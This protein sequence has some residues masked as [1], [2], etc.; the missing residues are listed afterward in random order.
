METLQDKRRKTEG[1][2]TCIPL[3]TISESNMSMDNEKID[4]FSRLPNGVMTQ[5]FHFLPMKE[6]IQTCMV[7]KNLRCLITSIPNLEFKDFVG[8]Q[9]KEKIRKKVETINKVLEHRDGPIRS[10]RLL[11]SSH[12]YDN[13]FDW[14]ITLL[15]GNGIQ[16]LDID[17]T[18]TK[19]IALP[20]FLFSSKTLRVLKLRSC[21]LKLPSIFT[22]LSALET[23]TLRNMSLSED[24]IHALLPQCNLLRNLTIQNCFNILK[25]DIS[26][27]NITLESLTL[28]NC[29]FHTAVEA[30][31][32]K[33]LSFHG[34]KT[35][36]SVKG[37]RNMVNAKIFR[38]DRTL[39]SR[40]EGNSLKD[41]VLVKLLY[42][43]SLSLTG[44]AFKCFAAGDL[45][46]MMQIS[47]TKI[48]KLELEVSS[49]N[50]KELEG[51][52]CLFRSCPNAEYLILWIN[53]DNADESY[54][55]NYEEEEEEEEVD[56]V[57]TYW[58]GVKNSSQL[59]GCVNHSLLWIKINDFIGLDTEVH[60]VEFLVANSRWL[61]TI[62]INPV[63]TMDSNEQLNFADLFNRLPRPC[64]DTQI[65]FN[66]SRKKLTYDEDLFYSHLLSD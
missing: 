41:N 42:V 57:N 20:S 48:K 62:T 11:L 32:I 2:G 14:W 25:F 10:C 44:W 53:E 46:E 33:S 7:S 5:I 12:S 61:R 64:A 52:V 17:F 26:D 51:M 9:T 28:E 58:K 66:Q 65:V 6:T 43:Q 18:A 27:C 23:L 40:E 29:S 63:E 24:L 47:Y 37:G 60:L 39:V 21:I 8:L 19:P 31:N 50:V 16:E 4:Y 22:G 15:I 59:Y 55:G 54:I 34:G 45:T 56:D 49:R 38:N 36:F 1:S 13:H 30:P 35:N 3:S